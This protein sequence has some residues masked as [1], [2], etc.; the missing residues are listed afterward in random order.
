MNG[1]EAIDDSEEGIVIAY[2]GINMELDRHRSR[3][4]GI[5]RGN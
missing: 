2:R 1:T 3:D 5:Q 4:K